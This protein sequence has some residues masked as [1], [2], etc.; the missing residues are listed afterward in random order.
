MH[1]RRRLQGVARAFR[2]HF[3][4]GDGAQFRVHRF[5]KLV[6]RPRV[7][8]GGIS[9]QLRHVA[10][11]RQIDRCRAESLSPKSGWFSPGD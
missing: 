11:G 5:I 8:P 10:H 2:S 9:K 3:L 4:N 7:P 1:Q 6:Q